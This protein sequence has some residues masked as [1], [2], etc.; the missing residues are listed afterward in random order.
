MSG[1]IYVYNLWELASF[2]SVWFSWEPSKL[3]RVSVSEVKVAQSCPAPCDP[4]D[5]TDHGILRLE[6]WSE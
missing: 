1:V 6:Y 3:L 5:Y 2:Q 4:M